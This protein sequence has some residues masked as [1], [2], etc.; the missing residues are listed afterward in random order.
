MLELTL[1][2][3]AGTGSMVVGGK[4]LNGAGSLWG[5]CGLS[6]AI[7]VGERTLGR[8]CLWA[9]VQYVSP[10]V[11]RERLDL[12]LEVGRHGHGL[13]QAAVRGTVG[14]RLALLAT[15]T[16][17]GAGATTTQFVAAPTDVPAPQDCPERVLPQSLRHA[18]TGMLSQIEQR[19]AYLPERELDGTVGAGRTAIWVRT[20][21][22]M[23]TSSAALA[24]L[25]DLAPAALTEAVGEMAYGVSLDNSIRVASMVQTDWVLLDVQVEAVLRDVAQLA[26][27]MFSQDGQLLAIAGQSAMTY[28]IDG[29]LRRLRA[30]GLP[31]ASGGTAGSGGTSATASAR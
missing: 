23:A 27:R 4:L 11:V 28:R 16:F 7:A 10:I 22:P 1:D 17:G 19:W 8:D 26:A 24:V 31:A 21:H 14:G 5:G 9:T 6:A 20:R 15:G 30:A 2:H 18:Q 3:D 12:A 13:S 29:R 25:A